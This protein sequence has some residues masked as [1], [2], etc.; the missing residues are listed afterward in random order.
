MI[1]VDFSHC[2]LKGNLPVLCTDLENV[3]AAIKHCVQR[4]GIMAE[5]GLRE[6]LHHV[7]DCGMDDNEVDE[8]T[9]DEVLND[10]KAQEDLHR[11]KVAMEE[12]DILADV[13]G[14]DAYEQYK[15]TKLN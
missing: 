6:L 9:V 4:D 13:L 3:I 12:Q 2:E 7:V 5:D 8:H 11:M 15:K 14:N 10:P 1:K